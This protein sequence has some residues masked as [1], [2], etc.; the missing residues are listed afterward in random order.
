MKQLEPEIK[1]VYQK[2]ILVFALL[3]FPAVSLQLLDAQPWTALIPEK[4]E[5]GE[6]WRVISAHFMHVNWHH[7]AMNMAG[8]ALCLA[9]FRF[10]IAAK[11]WLMSAVLISLFSSSLIY[12][13]YLPT[14]SYVGFSDTLHG[15]I[16]IGIL[17]MLT[18][19]PK[20][21]T[22]MLTVL[23]GKLLYENFI[24]PP[25]AELLQGSRVATESHLFGALGG[26]I[27]SVL[28]NNKLQQ[29]L[30]TIIFRQK[31]SG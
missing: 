30:S 27:Y 28:F 26:L 3:F 13:F 31:K 5:N 21:A 1:Q 16:V 2:L 20:L 9:V 15:W 11:H 25:S 17:A 29:F 14:Q 18:T 24:E 12:L 19:E 4:I 23:I 6:L 10:D 8:A 22:A 7:F